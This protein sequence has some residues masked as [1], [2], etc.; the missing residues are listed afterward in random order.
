[1]RRELLARRRRQQRIQG[2]TSVFGLIISILIVFYIFGVDTSAHS[3]EEQPEYK[4]FTNYELSSGDTLWSIAEE[5]RDEHYT[6][7][8]DYINEV[9]L[10]NSISKE[11]RLIS[12]TNLIIPYYSHTFMP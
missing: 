12:G 6:T 11:S 5:Y 3:I 4:Y 9:C 10:I 8:E 2:I 1:M 7:I